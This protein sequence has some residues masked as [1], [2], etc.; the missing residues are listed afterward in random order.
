[1]M[2]SIHY[3]FSTRHLLNRIV[4]LLVGA[5]ELGAGMVSNC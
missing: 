5:I 2:S 1:M 4:L 3:T